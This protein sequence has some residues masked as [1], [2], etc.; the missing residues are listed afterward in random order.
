MND[1]VTITVYLLLQVLHHGPPPPIPPVHDVLHHAVAAPAPLLS[2]HHDLP[3]DLGQHHLP[4]KVG[5]SKYLHYLQHSI[6]TIYSVDI[7]TLST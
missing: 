1:Q 4:V 7:S 2:L 6:Y 3:P 5:V